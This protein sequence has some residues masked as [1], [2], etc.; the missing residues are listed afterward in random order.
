MFVH[1]SHDEEIEKL[2]A[3]D[4]ESALDA[5]AEEEY[6]KKLAHMDEEK[7]EEEPDEGDEKEEV[8]GALEPKALPEPPPEKKSFI[9]IGGELP[10]SKENAEY[11]SPSVREQVNNDLQRKWRTMVCVSEVISDIVNM[12]KDKPVIAGP[13]HAFQSRL[14]IFDMLGDLDVSTN[15]AENHSPFTRM[16]S[17]DLNAIRIWMTVFAELHKADSEDG[18]K[19]GDKAVGAKVVS[20]QD[21]VFSK[22]APALRVL[23]SM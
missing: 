22:H 18:S 15:W 13:L 2:F 9:C 6:A 17:V 11:L 7:D 14:W 12:L 23:T 5:L 10:D 3:Q 20:D 4:R 19:D 21:I 1:I 16:P 8:E